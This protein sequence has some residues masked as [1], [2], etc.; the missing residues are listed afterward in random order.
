[1]KINLANV[2]LVICFA[3]FAASIFYA[4]N[5]V[6]AVRQQRSEIYCIEGLAYN[7]IDGGY[8]EVTPARKC[9]TET[10]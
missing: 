4:I 6:K 2:V 3:G 7:R 5:T 1:M 8:L 10:K 9:F